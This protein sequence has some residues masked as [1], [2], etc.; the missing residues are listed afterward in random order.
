[1]QSTEDAEKA[2]EALDGTDYD[3]RTL[4]V[5]EARAQQSRPKS[6]GYQNRDG[7]GGG[8]KRY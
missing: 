2:M 6:G 8:Y 3:G 7:G 5:N 1:M 4:R